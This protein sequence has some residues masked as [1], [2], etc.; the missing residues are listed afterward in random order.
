MSAESPV[1]LPVIAPL[2]KCICQLCSCGCHHCPHVRI[3]P[4]DKSE[5]PCMLSEYREQYPLHP[6]TAPR[7]SFKPKEA[8]KTEDIPME[9][10][11]TM[12]RDYLAHEVLPKKVKPPAEYVKSDKTMD[13]ASTYK[14]DYNAHSISQ[15]PPCLPPL[16]HIPKGKMDT[17]TTYKDD[18]VLWKGPR[19]EIMRPNNRFC[20]PEEKFKHKSLVQ[21][22]YRY[23]GP[24]TTESCRPLNVDQK[25]KA[26]F[27]EMTNYKVAY[28]PHLLEKRYAR[29][30]EEY[31]ASEVPFDGLTTHSVSYKGL[32]G[33][34]AKP[35]KPGQTKLPEIPFSSST[36]VQ[37]NYQPWPR[38]PVFTR[39][40]DVY[41]PPL[42]KMDLHSTCQIDYKH[43][44]GKPATSC[45]PLAKLNKSA[46][47]FNSSS[48]MKED[49]KSWLCKKQEPIIQTPQLTLPDRPMDCLTTFQANYVP[50]PASVTKS[51]KPAWS[52]PQQGA[53]LDATT[54][55]A[56]A[57]TPKGTVR[58]LASYKHP[59][60]YVFETTDADGHQVYHAVSKSEC[61]QS[62][63]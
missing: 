13:L 62:G 56:T 54:T 26:P 23:R 8:C 42:E 4:Y 16:R 34:P 37:D 22:D 35:V 47:P 43:L 9:G 53:P 17:R 63:D 41:L 19:T 57:Y 58:C 49:Y 6:S 44:N 12:K 10:I 39:K 30:P 55:Y 61:M 18:Y 38:L 15:V 31:K 48:V 1:E 24:V 14:Q 46:G 59:P 21:D 33:Q 50:H 5:K 7:D 25:S 52:V 20:P 60:G 29:K 27:Q 40:P 36:E 11:S 32:A 2:K 3:G 51:C 45:R 28:V